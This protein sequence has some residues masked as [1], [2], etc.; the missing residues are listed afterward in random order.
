LEILR[1]VEKNT[2]G[3]KYSEEI[4][5]K[6]TIEKNTNNREDTESSKREKR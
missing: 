3:G 2:R 6:N 5:E 4:Q 1:G